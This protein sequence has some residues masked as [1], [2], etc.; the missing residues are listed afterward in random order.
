MR[1]HTNKHPMIPPCIHHFINNTVIQR[2]LLSYGMVCDTDICDLLAQVLNRECCVGLVPF[3]EE[4]LGAFSVD[5][6][7]GK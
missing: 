1:Q 6:T 7:I 3:N 2:S 4:G 5:T